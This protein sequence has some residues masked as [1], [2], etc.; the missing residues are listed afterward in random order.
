V[1]VYP[2]QVWYGH[3]TPADVDD[4]VQQHI[5][6]GKPVERLVIPDRELTGLEE[7]QGGSHGSAR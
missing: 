2:E 3:V 1:V 7:K 4:I 6:G 5:L